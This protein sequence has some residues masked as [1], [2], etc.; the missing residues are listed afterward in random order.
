LS[1]Q[2]PKSQARTDRDDHVAG[3]GAVRVSGPYRGVPRLA[4]GSDR[5]PRGSTESPAG[6]RLLRHGPAGRDD[7]LDARPSPRRAVR[8]LQRP[9]RDAEAADDRLRGEPRDSSADGLVADAGSL[10]RKGVSHLGQHGAARGD[11]PRPL[12]LIPT[13]PPA[14]LHLER[15]RTPATPPPRHRPGAEW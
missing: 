2:L 1:L 9:A 3:D 13:S 10:L 4:G 12:S 7:R 5:P 6:G 11:P 14:R 15:L 8:L